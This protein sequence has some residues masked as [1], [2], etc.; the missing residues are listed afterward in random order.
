MQHYPPISS[1][2][3][4]RFG[5][6]LKQ[7]G[8]SLYDLLITSTIAGV[9][10]AGTA[11]LSGLAQ[12]TLLTASVN[13][14]MGD[15]NFARSEA[16]KRHT[17]MVLCKSDNGSACSNKTAWREGWIVFTDDNNNHNVDTGET[18][19]H[20]QQ[21]LGGDMTLRYGSLHE[22]VRYSPTSETWT[23]TF[24]FCDGRGEKNAKA[25]I[26]YWTGRPRVSTKTS[27]DKPLH[28]S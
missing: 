2:H 27:E 21:R 12:D 18:V 16:I 17:T 8:Y 23:G 11:G 3:R 10:T 22:Y 6:G 13:R 4:W 7:A 14:L 15:L 19:V 9:L 24:T 28:C 25:V 26:I 5:L 1:C 20:L